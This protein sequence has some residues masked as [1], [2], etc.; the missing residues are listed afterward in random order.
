MSD[1]TRLK[2]DLETW[3][4]SSDYVIF[5]MERERTQKQLNSCSTIATYIENI[6]QQETDRLTTDDIQPQ[7]L[8]SPLVLL[9]VQKLIPFMLLKIVLLLKKMTSLLVN[10]LLPFLLL[11]FSVA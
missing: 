7:Q 9:L 4:Q 6:L 3:K 1:R 5:Y 8:V 2:A 11:P 10:H